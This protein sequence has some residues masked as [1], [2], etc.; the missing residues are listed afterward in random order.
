MGRLDL[1]HLSL[2][3]TTRNGAFL[4]LANVDLAVEDGEF[5]TI[6]GP[7]GCGK[8]TLLMLIAALLAPSS[9]SVRLDGRPVTAPGSDRALVFQDFALLPWRTVLANVE[10]GLELKGVPAAQ[11]SA[12]ARRHIAMVGLAA[13]ERS[14]PHQLS[15][16]MRQRVGIAR[17]LAV[18]PQVLLMDE[19]FGA[20]DAQ[21]RQVMGSELLRI[22]ERGRKTILFVTHDIDE[23]IYLADR[24][25]VMSASP[26]RVIA[27]IAVTLARPRPLEIRNDPAF[28]AYRQRIWDLLAGE[29][30]ASNTWEQPAAAAMA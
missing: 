16:G 27:D 12:I 1:D 9:G 4:A 11:R 8:S 19:P 15:G 14:Y 28:T 23:A 7:S 24:I 29:V 21:I 22:W 30:L 17:A 25:I 5:V 13:F 26:G 10:L 6:V 2:S 18:E 20:L 3:Y